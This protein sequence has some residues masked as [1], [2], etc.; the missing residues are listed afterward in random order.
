MDF[1]PGGSRY[2]IGKWTAGRRCG[3]QSYA[4][5]VRACFII[6][7]DAG[8]FALGGIVSSISVKGIIIGNLTLLLAGVV[9]GVVLVVVYAAPY[10]L[11]DFERL[12]ESILSGIG[13]PGV[14]FLNGIAAVIAGY[15]A[16][17]VAGKGEL[18]NGALSSILV[19]GYDIFTIVSLADEFVIYDVADLALAPLLGLLGG[20]VRLSLMRISAA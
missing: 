2:R 15:V 8:A 12:E 13:M 6:G 20:Y 16:A 4:S 3:A 11:E 18:I 7:R 1:E 19:I 17:W 5:R 10:A 9:I 14:L